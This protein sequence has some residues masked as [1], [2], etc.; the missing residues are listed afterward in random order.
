LLNYSND[1]EIK[2]YLKLLKMKW[3]SKNRQVLERVRL[4]LDQCKNVGLSYLLLSVEL[5]LTRVLKLKEENKRLHHKLMKHFE[6]I[7]IAC[8]NSV[9][10]SL[11]MDGAYNANNN[12]KAFRTWSETHLNDHVDIA[13]ELNAKAIKFD[14]DGE[15]DKAAIVYYCVFQ[16][17]L[18]YPHPI[19]NQRTQQRCLVQEIF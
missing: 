8:R 19:Y 5:N 6:K 4:E 14:R 3:V 11:K 15:D 12:F 13:L 18:K 10:K 9:G 16:N 17:A 1:E 7:P 2:R